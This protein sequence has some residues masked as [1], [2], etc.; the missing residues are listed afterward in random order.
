MKEI[1]LQMDDEVFV[2]A[3]RYATDREKT[4]ED[5]LL[6]YVDDLANYNPF[7]RGALYKDCPVGKDRVNCVSGRVQRDG[8]GA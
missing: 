3:E 4:P 8:T 6:E 1:R 5:V 7:S 2:A